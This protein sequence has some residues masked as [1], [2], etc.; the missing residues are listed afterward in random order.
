M[1]T[2]QHRRGSR[3]KGWEF[4][5]P[6]QIVRLRARVEAQ[7][8]W[9]IALLDSLDGDADFEP[10]CDAE[11]GADAEP[12]SDAELDADAEPDYRGGWSRPAATFAP[13]VIIGPEGHPYTFRPVI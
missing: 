13:V 8:E 1:S 12:D 3:P 2:L 11:E 5:H 6:G 4:P 9:L 7:V 10:D